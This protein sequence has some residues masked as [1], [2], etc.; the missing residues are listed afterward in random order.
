[1]LPCTIQHQFL[2]VKARVNC[3]AADTS[4]PAPA[5]LWSLS[6]VSVSSPFNYWCVRY[7]KSHQSLWCHLMNVLS[8]SRRIDCVVIQL[9]YNFPLGV[10]YQPKVAVFSTQTD[11]ISTEEN[12]VQCNRAWYIEDEDEDG[13]EDEAT[14]DPTTLHDAG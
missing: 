8:H 10:Q 2:A 11:S 6:I 3:R 4:L 13:M 14:T 7:R 12:G 9:H 1:M 5:L